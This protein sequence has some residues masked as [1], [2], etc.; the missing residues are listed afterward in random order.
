[1]N[2]N[3]VIERMREDHGRVLGAVESLERLLPADGPAGLPPGPVLDGLVRL[4]EAQFGTHMAAEEEV[5]FP[6]LLVLV[7]ETRASVAPLSAE[8]Q[9]L[10]GMLDALSALLEA[11]TRPERDEQIVVQVRDLADLL[12]IHIR[13]EETAVFRLAERVLRPE[14]FQAIGA[15]LEPSNTPRR[16]HP[17]AASTGGNPCSPPSA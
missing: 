15:R 3:P 13:K 6:T 7:P 12:R 4:L 10:R 1:M 11:P 9:D 8:H 16:G 2:L 14:D 5:L 17:P